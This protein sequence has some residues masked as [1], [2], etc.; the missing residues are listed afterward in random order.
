MSPQHVRVVITS[1]RFFGTGT[2]LE[3]TIARDFPGLAVEVETLLAPDDATMIEVARDADAIVTSSV[4][5]VPR[6]VIEALPQL[7]VIGRYAVGYD[8]ID[9]VA[10]RDH[11]IVV[12][13]YPGY[14]TDEVADHA[15][16]LILA[17]NRRLFPS[18]RRVREGHWAGHNLETAHVAGGEILPMREQTIGVIGMGRIGRA[19]VARLRP[20]GPEILV[21]DPAMDGDAVRNL[22]AGL[23]PLDELLGRADIVTI[24]CPLSPDTRHL[25]SG[26][27]LATMRPG[28]ALVNTARG[29]IVDGDALSEALRSGHLSAAA[30]DVMEREPLQLGDPLLDVPNLILTPHSAYYS[31][32]SMEALRRETY[33]DVLT[34]LAGGRARTQVLPPRT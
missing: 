17:L 13:H 2:E 31:E 23:V 22:G 33:V 11:G 24:H 3:A 14:C 7:K 10:A 6:T 28:S 15:L 26:D 9:L 20:F 21:A 8:N 16:S 5:A 12:T 4:D 18:D 34:V 30:L 1:D 25:I 32:R 27:Q 29:P 19:V